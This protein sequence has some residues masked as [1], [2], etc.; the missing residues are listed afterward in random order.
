MSYWFPPLYCTGCA[1]TGI[2]YPIINLSYWFPPLYCTSCACTGIKYPIIN[3]GYWFPPLYCTGCACTGIKYPIINLNY[4]F[5]PLYCT[6][7]KYL[8]V[9]PGVASPMTG[10]PF[11]SRVWVPSASVI[12]SPAVAYATSISTRPGAF[13]SVT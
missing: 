12:A 3:L 10:L 5:P 8:I 2:K 11:S 13:C 7:I 1:C 9:A 6:G 4:W